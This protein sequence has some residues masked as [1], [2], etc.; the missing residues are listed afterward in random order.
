[1]SRPCHPDAAREPQPAA[2]TVA[3]GPRSAAVGA[4]VWHPA[5]VELLARWVVED[6]LS[7]STV[8]EQ[9]EQSPVGGATR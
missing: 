9:S 8:G 4:V 6:A 5:L 1:M 7:G 3:R 2:V